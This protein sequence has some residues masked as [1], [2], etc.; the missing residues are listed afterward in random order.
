VKVSDQP[1]PDPQPQAEE[2][3]F[4]SLPDGELPASLTE[5]M[6]AAW[7]KREPKWYERLAPA[8]KHWVDKLVAIR[9]QEFEG[10]LAA[11]DREDSQLA[12]QIAEL[13]AQ[14]VSLNKR[15]VTLEDRIAELESGP[16]A[17]RQE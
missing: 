1:G 7:E 4:E 8:Q 15:L 16:K 5:R 6:A 13:T 14:V 9:L 3:D 2:N 10:H 12:H 11:L 17:N